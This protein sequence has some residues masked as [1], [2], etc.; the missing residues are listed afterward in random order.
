VKSLSIRSRIIIPFVIIVLFILSLSIILFYRHIEIYIKSDFQIRKEK[1]LQAF[2]HELNIET[3]V[4]KGF[5]NL[6]KLKE[7]LQSAWLEGNR[8][9]LLA[10]SIHLNNTLIKSFDIT[11]FY[12]HNMDKTCFLRVH[13]PGRFGDYIDRY[14]LERAEKTSFVSSGI[15][16]GPYGTFTLRV[17]SPWII[18]GKLVGYIE[19]GK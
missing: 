7:D 15:E 12:F 18:G 16:L 8:D 4:I 14:T 10:K 1:V 5:L 11:H 19:L 13:N 6:L 3:E 9:L 17:V 2:D